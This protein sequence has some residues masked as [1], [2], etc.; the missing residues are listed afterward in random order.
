M[1]TAPIVL[2]LLAF[3][4]APPTVRAAT[5]AAELSI[6]RATVGSWIGLAVEDPVVAELP[7]LGSVEIRLTAP[8]RVRFVDGGVEGRLAVAVPTL[9]WRGEVDLRFEPRI[10]RR[11]GTVRF[12]ATS[13]RLVG[14][15]PPAVDLARWIPAIPLPRSLGGDIELAGGRRLPLHAWVHG[16]RIDEQRVYLKLGIDLP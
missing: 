15:S 6:D 5:G 7:G 11:A 10:E 13:A 12:V 1:K 9:G 8:S 4:A 2:L 3:G 16:L 14:P